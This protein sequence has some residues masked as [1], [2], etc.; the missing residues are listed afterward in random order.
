[1]SIK[2]LILITIYVLLIDGLF[3]Q[4]CIKPYWENIIR[5]IQNSPLYIRP[6]YAFFAY[7]FIIL[8]IYYFV[9]IPEYHICNAIVLGFVLYGVFGFTLGALLKEYPYW[10]IL[11]YIIWGT[12]MITISSHLSQYTWTKIE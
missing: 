9:F 6:L 10:I 3:I 4:L 12:F 5:N 7:I 1:M 2:L 11:L 8:G